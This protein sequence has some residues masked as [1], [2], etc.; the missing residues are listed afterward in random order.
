M[1]FFSDLFSRAG[2]VVRGQASKGMDV[3]EDATFESTLK[4]TVPEI[5]K[6]LGVDSLG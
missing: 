2:R 4:Q 3:V 5:T 6:K 1:G